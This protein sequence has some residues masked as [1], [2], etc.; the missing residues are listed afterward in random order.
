M[1][2]HL[3][4]TLP[5]TQRYLA[6]MVRDGGISESMAVLALEQSDGIGSRGNT[7][8]GARGNFHA[9]IALRAG[10]LPQ[11][12]PLLSASIYFGWLMRELLED[13]GC[14]VWLK[15]PNDIYTARG[16]AGG[17]ITQKIGDFLIVG[18]G[19]NLAREPAG[20]ASVEANIEPLELCR[21]YIGKIEERVSW[22]DIF[23]KYQLEFELNR[24]AFFHMEERVESL[25]EAR[26][27]DDGSLIVKGERIVSLR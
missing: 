23:S 16:K 19:V 11:D 24:A 20:Y 12:L 3:F 26:L 13:I 21:L 5:S 9:S 7:W 6:G 14:S 22:K 25:R 17:V 4:E 10:Q 27:C 1:E 15:W 2:I 18:I 8:I